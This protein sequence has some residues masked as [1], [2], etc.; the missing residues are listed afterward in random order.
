MK[1][2]VLFCSVKI[3]QRMFGCYQFLS[4]SKFV[5]CTDRMDLTSQEN[6]IKKDSAMLELG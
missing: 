2:R 5:T 6:N 4:K 3:A 1:Y